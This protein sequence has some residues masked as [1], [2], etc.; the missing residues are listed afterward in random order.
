[1]AGGAARGCLE[2]PAE[3]VKTRQQVGAPWGRGALLRGAWSTCLRTSSAVG[4]F[5]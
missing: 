1:A 5:W 3:L 2:A 4:C